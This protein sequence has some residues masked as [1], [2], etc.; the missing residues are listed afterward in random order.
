MIRKLN[1][2]EKGAGS[3]QWAKIKQELGGELFTGSSPSLREHE[4]VA[5]MTRVWL[6]DCP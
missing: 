6:P 1:S 3:R 2:E 4:S 5:V